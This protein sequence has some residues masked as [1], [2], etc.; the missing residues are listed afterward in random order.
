[1]QAFRFG[2]QTRSGRGWMSTLVCAW[3]VFGLC[4]HAALAQEPA[5]DGAANTGGA[6]ERIAVVPFRI[7]SA[8]MADQLG[9]TLV[10]TD[11]RL[12]GTSL[13]SDKEGR[14]VDGGSVGA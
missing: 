7:H 3:A 1:M 5:A 9:R 13:A 4:A 2:R 10:L 14:L 12:D 6:V 11:G 8:R